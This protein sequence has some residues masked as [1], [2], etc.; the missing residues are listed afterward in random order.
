MRPWGQDQAVRR[1]CVSWLSCREGIQQI[2]IKGIRSRNCIISL[3]DIKKTENSHCV[4]THT[5]IK[6]E[7]LC[8]IM[9]SYFRDW[10]FSNRTITETFTKYSMTFSV[11]N[12]SQTWIWG[13]RSWAWWCVPL[14]PGLR[15]P[16][17]ATMRH[18]PRGEVVRQ[19]M[20]TPHEE[21]ICPLLK[22]YLNQWLWKCCF[23]VH[24]HGSPTLILQWWL[25]KA[26]NKG[27]T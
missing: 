18:F 12:E 2:K 27:R 25:W 16:A 26:K 19:W 13:I 17:W 22:P 11:K 3:N 8:K 23:C 5:H 20:R 14:F 21:G 10:I 24:M 1:F 6:G 7:K 4:S 15:G 9:N